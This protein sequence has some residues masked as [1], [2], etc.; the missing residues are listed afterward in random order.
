MGDTKLNPFPIPTP[1]THYTI[2][3]L[4]SHLFRHPCIWLLSLLLPPPDIYPRLSLHCKHDILNWRVSNDRL[5]HAEIIRKLL[6]RQNSQA[7]RLVT[8]SEAHE[9]RSQWMVTGR[10]DKWHLHTLCFNPKELPNV[11][12]E[13]TNNSPFRNDD[14]D[15]EV[16]EWRERGRR[17]PF[18]RITFDTEEEGQV[19]ETNCRL[20]GGYSNFLF[21]PLI[22]NFI[23][24]IL[25]ICIN[26]GSISQGPDSPC[27]KG[28]VN[29]WSG[30]CL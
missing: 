21:F 4:Y 23:R 8:F 16:N 22:T 25:L 9:G 18:P 14:G 19:R 3:I 7:I 20:V 15:Y 17:H 27:A 1:I 30:H 5:W 12:G 28:P 13:D 2:Q 11:F 6:P 10:K 26:S 29:D 24:Q